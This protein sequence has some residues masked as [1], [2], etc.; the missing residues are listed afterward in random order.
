MILETLIA[1]IRELADYFSGGPKPPY[2]PLPSRDS[3]IL[4]RR[5]TR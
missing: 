3:H 2:R 1:A 4:N 5:R